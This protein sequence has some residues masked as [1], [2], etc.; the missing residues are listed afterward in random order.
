[1]KKILIAMITV[2]LLVGC[3]AKGDN[4]SKEFKVGV[5]QW[6]NHPALDDSYTGMVKGLEEAGL[7]DRVSITHQ[8][9]NGQAPDADQIISQFVAEGVDLIYAIAT[10]AAQSALNAVEGNNIKVVFAAVT[11]PIA[12]NLVDEDGLSDVVTGVSDAAP[13]ESHMNLIKEFLPD[14]SKVGVLFKTSEANSL[15]QIEQLKELLPSMDLEL[16]SKGVNE[17]SEISFA[18]TQVASEVDAFYIITDNL[19]ATAAGVLV[20]A[21]VKK[22]IPVFMAEDGQFDQGIFASDSISY[23]NMGIQ[24]GTMISSI[25]TKESTVRDLPFQISNETNLLVSKKMAEELGIEIPKAI[26]ERAEV[27]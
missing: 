1:M 2:L 10:P 14:A 20:D 22:G 12:T 16:V 21:G 17:H 27:R 24:A 4:T 15:L 3:S 11:D 7:M 5:V 18:A 8:V 25:L 23:E 13:I 9:A 19:I 26:Q 6:D